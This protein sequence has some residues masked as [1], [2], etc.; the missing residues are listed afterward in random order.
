MDRRYYRVH[1]R[2]DEVDAFLIWFSSDVDGV[3]VEGDGLV[4]TFRIEAEMDAFAERRGITFVSE[5]ASEF[6]FDAVE[7]WLSKPG[8]ST[9]D[10]NLLLG[11]WNLFDD[12]ASSMGDEAFVRK[13][14]EAPGVYEKMFWGNNLPS[15]TPTGE[16]FVPVW[17]DGE[18]AE[19][20][21]ILSEG[22]TLFR[23]AV[24]LIM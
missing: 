9:I 5:P 2:L 6:D 24:R 7:H 23:N 12:V 10:C 15:V 13:S 1:F 21:R 3:V 4:P 14:R 16:H 20:R 11:A 22:M 8:D 17:S 18:V 19:I